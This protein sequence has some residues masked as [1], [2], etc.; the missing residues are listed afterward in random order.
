VPSFIAVYVGGVVDAEYSKTLFAK[1]IGFGFGMPSTAGEIGTALW[2]AIRGARNIV[3]RFEGP[4][5]PAKS[6]P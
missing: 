1:A 5:E 6:P 2:L 4:I 3:K